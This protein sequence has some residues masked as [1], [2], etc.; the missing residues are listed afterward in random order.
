MGSGATRRTSR[1]T[2][3]N[4]TGGPGGGGR[5]SIAI[6]VPVII[7]ALGTIAIVTFIYINAN[8]TYPVVVA[9][10]DLQ[11]GQTVTAMDFAIAKVKQVPPGSITDLSD[12]RLNGAMQIPL[13][14]DNPVPSTAIGQP[15]AVTTAAP[16]PPPQ[17]I[18]CELYGG[19]QKVT[20]VFTGQ[21]ALQDFIRTDCANTKVV[22]IYST[23]NTTS[24]NRITRLLSNSAR[25]IAVKRPPQPENPQQA[26][27]PPVASVTF[28]VPEGEA[29]KLIGDSQTVGKKIKLLEG[30]DRIP[31][32]SQADIVQQFIGI[33]MDEQEIP[34]EVGNTLINKAAN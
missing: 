12:P 17:D 9:A 6:L 19:E 13:A 28:A 18:V 30:P 27:P 11:Q 20:V 2:R 26:P 23:F 24:G 15:V 21:D 4:P 31:P 25:I 8:K 10:R 5:P 34:L 1:I 32:P 33:G 3:R 7:L 14:K 29:V 16:P 22:T